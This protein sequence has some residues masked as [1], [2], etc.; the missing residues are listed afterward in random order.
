MVLL[1]ASVS[2]VGHQSLLLQGT[3]MLTYITWRQW[4]NFGVQKDI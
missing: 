2:S 4:G 1:I 3:D